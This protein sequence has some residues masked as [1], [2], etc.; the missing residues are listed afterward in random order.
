M[1]TVDMEQKMIKEG[2][3]FSKDLEDNKWVAEFA[4]EVVASHRNR[5][6][7]IWAAASFLNMK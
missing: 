5:G 4:D 1:S 2:V 3:S 7:C 6:D